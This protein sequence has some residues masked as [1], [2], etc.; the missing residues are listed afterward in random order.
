MAA[1]RKPWS[2]YKREFMARHGGLTPSQWKTQQARKAGTTVYRKRRQAQ[3]RRAL[4]IPARAN[5]LPSEESV[6]PRII[7]LSGKS[8]PV[9]PS[10]LEYVRQL[11]EQ[12]SPPPEVFEESGIAKRGYVK[13]PQGRKIRISFALRNEYATRREVAAMANVYDVALGRRSNRY[14]LAFYNAIV[15]P[16][17]NWD[18]MMEDGYRKMNGTFPYTN[19]QWFDYVTSISALSYGRPLMTIDEFEDRYG[20]RYRGN[21]WIDTSRAL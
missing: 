11:N 17:Y 2:Q 12:Y 3:T 6:A 13:G 19:K 9:T 4:D 21:E 7:D 5:L 8:H 18:A 14:A 20:G 10:W 1:K 16:R 15:N